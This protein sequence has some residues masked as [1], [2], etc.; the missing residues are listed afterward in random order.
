ML[1]SL[2]SLDSW[3]PMLWINFSKTVIESGG[4]SPSYCDIYVRMIELCPHQ[5]SEP[6]ARPKSPRSRKRSP[7]KLEETALRSLELTTSLPTTSPR[8]SR[9]RPNALYGRISTDFFAGVS[10]VLHLA[11][12]LAGKLPPA[13]MLDVSVHAH[14]LLLAPSRLTCFYVIRPRL[15]EQ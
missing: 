3:D 12:P 2:V 13:E 1:R 8:L 9:V 7:L 6:L 5:P 4:G 15:T 14:T 10:G 11:S